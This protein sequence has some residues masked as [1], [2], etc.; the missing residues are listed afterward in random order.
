MYSFSNATSFSDFYNFI[1]DTD[2]VTATGDVLS[3]DGV[4]SETSMQKA[5]KHALGFRFLPNYDF[6]RKNKN[7]LL[8]GRS[9]KSVVSRK[10]NQRV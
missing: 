5:E 1:E 7:R 6:K 4:L 8:S 9:A 10:S 2:L 3:K